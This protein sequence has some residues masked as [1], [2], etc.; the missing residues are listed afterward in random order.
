MTSVVEYISSLTRLGHPIAELLCAPTDPK[1]VAEYELRTGL[2][3]PDP[4]AR[5]FA[6]HDGTQFSDKWKLGHGQFIDGFYL[7]RFEEAMA[8][9]ELIDLSIEDYPY[10]CEEPHAFAGRSIFPFLANGCGDNIVVDICP[11]S[12]RFG[13]IGSC[14]HADVSLPDE[15]QDFDSFLAGHVEA[16]SAGVYRIN[17]EGY[18]HADFEDLDSILARHKIAEGEQAAS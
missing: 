5:L 12:N 16:V 2:K 17:S 10:Y 4:I 14:F 7:M 9:K 11:K 3:L 15:F 1:I 6:I 18:M 8:E 13:Y